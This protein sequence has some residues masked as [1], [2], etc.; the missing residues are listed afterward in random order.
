MYQLQ[1]LW[2]VRYLRPWQICSQLS[3]RLKASYENPDKF[4]RKT[5]PSYPGRRWNLR[6]EFLA[7]GPQIISAADIMKG[8]LTF[9]NNM[10]NVGYPPRWNCGHLPKLWQYNLHYFEYLWAL[11]YDAAKRLAIDWIDNYPLA[12]DQ[13][14]WEPYPVSL[15]LMNL[16][17]VFFGQ[18]RKQIE[19]DDFFLKKLWSSIYLQAEWLTRHL[20]THL[21]GNHLFENAAALSFVGSCFKGNLATKWLDK[22]IDILTE[23]IPEQILPD[24]LHFER[25]PM[26]HCRII[27][28]LAVLFNTGHQQLV[29]LVKKALNKVIAA[30]GHLIHPDGQIALLND[31]AFGIYNTPDQLFFYLQSL[32]HNKND[33][34]SIIK[35]GPFALPD[36]GY[37]GFRNKEGTYIICDVAP[38]GSDYIPGHAHADIFS[39]ELSFKG[40]RVIVDS[41]VY[42]YEVSS[43]R[44]YCRSTRAHNT[45][46]IEGQDQCEMW[47]AFRVA[48]RGRPHDIKWLPD[49]N[50]GFQLGGWHD[51]YKRLKG[52]PIH[53]R[54]FIWDSRHKLVVIDKITA[55]CSQNMISRL[56]LHPDCSVS[57]L[58]DNFV[59]INYP[60]GKSKISF[61]GNGQLTIEKSFYCPEFGIKNANTVLKFSFS[62]QR[63]ATGFKIEIL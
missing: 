25:S 22:G 31:S 1:L 55:S 33:G 12:R 41:G 47:G 6:H 49:K 3:N 15:R 42:D 51:G 62:G 7:P 20:E 35:T 58:E 32:C 23:Q 56:H 11:D 48:R 4:L 10:Q 60:A 57:A 45:I 46:E 5:S 36:A 8:H 26:Y 63:I 29:D 19:A 38:I 17:G 44:K 30:L 52:K 40:Y 34:F 21:L 50:G 37:Y 18:Y 43:T 61:F 13:V 59:L 16:C 28:L 2:T 14:G 53:Y 27:Y 9:S 39:F 24:G 54:E